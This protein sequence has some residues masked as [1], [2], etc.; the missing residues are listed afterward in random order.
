MDP[1]V[2]FVGV[3][4]LALIFVLASFKARWLKV[5]PP[6]VIAA[7]VGLVLG[8]SLG[9]SGDRLI[10][11]PDHPFKHGIVWPNFHGMFT[12]PLAVVGA[13]RRRC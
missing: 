9:L 5:V 4:C 2:F 11:I 10:Q 3:F 7:A 12:R 8:W 13:G 1:K 6:Q